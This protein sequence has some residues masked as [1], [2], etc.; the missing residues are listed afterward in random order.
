MQRHS[1][2]LYAATNL[3][4]VCFFIIGGLKFSGLAAQT[5]SDEASW[6]SAI[7]L[8]FSI[9]FAYS[10]IRIAAERRW[11]TIAADWAFLS[12]LVSLMASVLIAA[13]ELSNG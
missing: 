12:G 2:I 4:S 3:L 11:H 9:F 6:V 1:H 10:T 13:V 5:Y 8:F 7:L